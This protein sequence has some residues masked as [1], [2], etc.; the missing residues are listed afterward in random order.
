AAPGFI[1]PVA[2]TVNGQVDYT[3]AGGTSFAAPHVAGIAALMLQ[4]NPHLTQVQIEDI[5]KNTAMPLPP[6]C[7]D[8]IFPG[9]GPGNPATW[10]DHGNL[11]FFPFTVCWGANATG[12]GLVQ[13]D[14]ALAATPLP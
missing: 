8:V 13:A 9:I 7:R 1:I 14:A 11:F 4:K 3:F 5:L 10:D 2:W 6:G 12:H